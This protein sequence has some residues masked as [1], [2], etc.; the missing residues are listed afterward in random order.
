M[1]RID[2]NIFFIVSSLKTSI[3]NKKPYNNTFNKK[4][5]KYTSKNILY[6]FI[7][8]DETH[9]QICLIFTL[10][11][12]RISFKKTTYII[13]GMNFYYSVFNDFFGNREKMERDF[14]EWLNYVS[15]L[16]SESE[17]LVILDG[18]FRSKIATNANIRIIFADPD[19][20][21]NRII[22]QAK[23]YDYDHQR[24]RVISDDRE[25]CSYIKEIGI[26]TIGCKKFYNLI[27]KDR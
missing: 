1:N 5:L 9:L 2:N 4:P 3:K 27:T 25:L 6:N 7:C 15:D 24:C 8:D 23:F 17:F 14:Y 21:D 10:H 26:K 12:N 18:S 13:D 11:M 16:F 20:A 22:E 19:D